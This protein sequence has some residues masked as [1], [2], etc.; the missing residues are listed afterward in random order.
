MIP[1]PSETIFN[2]E[3]AFDNR[4]SIAISLLT[5]GCQPVNKIRTDI[6]VVV[7]GIDKQVFI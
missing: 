1:L 4:L 6:H 3:V 5:T 2:L 7:C